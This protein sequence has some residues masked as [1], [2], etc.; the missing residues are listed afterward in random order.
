VTPET[1][2]EKLV[3]LDLAC[4]ERKQAGFL[5]VD[6]IKIPEVDCVWDLE[7]FPY[8]FKDNSVDEIYCSHYIEHTADVVRFMNEIFRMLKVGGKCTII[9][10]YYSSMRAW[11]DPTH[12][13]AISEATFLYFNKGWRTANKVN[14][15]LATDADFDF[16]YSYMITPE[17][18]NRNEEARAFAIAHYINV[19]SDIQIL[20]TKR[21]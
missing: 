5:G 7:K 9:A 10:P 4:G 8:P 20:L 21:G 2:Q 17:W 18:A 13:R 19:V 15:Y 12:R 14:H 6:K 11:Q 16:S 3:K 1:A